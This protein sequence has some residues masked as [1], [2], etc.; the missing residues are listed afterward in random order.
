M[1]DGIATVL[2][3]VY[4]QQAIWRRKNSSKGFWN[5][6]FGFFIKN[7]CEKNFF[8]SHVPMWMVIFA[9]QRVRFR[10]ALVSFSPQQK[11]NLKNFWKNKT[12]MALCYFS[13]IG[14]IFSKLLMCFAIVKFNHRKLA[15][16]RERESGAGET[17]EEED[18]KLF[19]MRR[20]PVRYVFKLTEYEMRKY[21][22]C[23]HQGKIWRRRSRGACLSKCP[24]RI[25]RGEIQT[26][27][28]GALKITTFQEKP[29]ATSGTWKMPKACVT[30][31]ASRWKHESLI[32]APHRCEDSIIIPRGGKLVQLQQRFVIRAEGGRSVQF[33]GSTCSGGE[34]PS[35][36][37]VKW[38]S[39]GQTRELTAGL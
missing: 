34:Q 16:E 11:S 1:A 32:R 24:D 2:A 19:Y 30:E 6:C 29:E 28:Q 35:V 18:T 12:P 13:R 37:G 9:N 31:T 25:T 15:E 20:F 4:S 8:P 26:L 21:R 39:A 14:R 23:K 10:V 27:C 22:S 38:I 36:N 7:V 17:E 3:D 5:F 33:C